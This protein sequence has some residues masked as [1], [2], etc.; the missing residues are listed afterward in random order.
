MHISSNSSYHTSATDEKTTHESAASDAF[1]LP[2]SPGISGGL[3]YYI[4][5]FHKNDG[6]ETPHR[7]WMVATN[8]STNH[9]LFFRPTCK[10]WSCPGCG[11]VNAEHWIRRGEKGTKEFLEQGWKVDFLTLTPHEKVTKEQ[12]FY[13]LPRAWKTLHMRYQREIPHDNP[14]AYF[15]VPERM[16]RSG[17]VHSH[18]MITGG[19]TQKWWKDNAREC[20]LGYQSKVIEI[21]DIGVVGYVTKYLTKT[22]TESWP[23]GRRRVNTSRNWPTIPMKE[24]PGWEF[25]THATD[26]QLSLILDVYVGEGLTILGLNTKNAWKVLNGLSQLT[27][28]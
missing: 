27:G 8:K 12:S 2:L 14:G 20:G 18:F 19:L 7:P 9:L 10:K 13:V 21:E 26:E 5:Q 1:S 6:C 4:E 22:L 17:K 23:K 11:Q 28:E 3:K 15:V 25:S 16:P 24:H